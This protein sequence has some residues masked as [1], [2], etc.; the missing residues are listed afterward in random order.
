MKGMGRLLR[1]QGCNAG[2]SARSGSW[3][4]VCCRDQ[5]RPSDAAAVCLLPAQGKPV[6]AAICRI[7]GPQMAEL[8]LVATKQTAR[9]Q[10]HARV[11]V[12]CFE[13]L[14]KQVRRCRATGGPSVL[15][16]CRGGPVLPAV[17]E[18]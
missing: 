8:P 14:L 18:P 1:R 16:P 12:N 13:Q 7:F 6:V 2:G 4:G 17:C 9:R 3:T 11:L 10:G 15:W 5:H